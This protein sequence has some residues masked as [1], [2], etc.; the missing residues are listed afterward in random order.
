[1]C[2]GTDKKGQS[3]Y[4]YNIPDTERL[5]YTFFVP[6]LE[7]VAGLALRS[8]IAKVGLVV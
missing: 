2:V 5:L 8:F 7:S 3:R 6:L 1:M 4:E